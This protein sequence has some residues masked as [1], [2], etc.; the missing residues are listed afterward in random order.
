MI[1]KSKF[2]W[3]DVENTSDEILTSEDENGD[4]ILT[5]PEKVI[6]ELGIQEGDTAVFEI[7]DDGEVLF[8]I[9]KE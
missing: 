4:L 7:K 6:S 2:S 3:S 9:E 5:F 8:S 1:F